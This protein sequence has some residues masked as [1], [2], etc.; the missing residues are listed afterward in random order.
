MLG[1]IITL[2]S[3]EKDEKLKDL[4]KEYYSLQFDE[5]ELLCKIPSY[6]DRFWFKRDPHFRVKEFFYINEKLIENIV[7]V[8]LSWYNNTPVNEW[9]QDAISFYHSMKY[10]DA[11]ECLNKII[12]VYESNDRL[13]S[14]ICKLRIIVALNNKGL[15]F[16]KLGKSDEAIKSFNKSCDIDPNVDS[17]FF[18]KIIIFLIKN[19]NL[20]KALELYD[21]ALEKDSS[22]SAIYYKNKADLLVKTIIEF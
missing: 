10:K 16:I 2:N 8:I 22:N 20:E 3:I 4:E 18:K 15:C 13:I 17:I 6:L 5:N 9:N 19:E 7:D 21:K 1:S 11:I 12:K 14:D